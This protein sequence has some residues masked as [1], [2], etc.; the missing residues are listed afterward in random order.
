MKTGMMI[1]W[2][3]GT[4]VLSL[5][6]EETTRSKEEA[7]RL[8][9]VLEQSLK[10]DPNNSTLWVH[11]GFANR[12]LDDIDGALAAFE[13]ATQLNPK[14]PDALYMLAI[15][16]EKKERNADAVKAWK[17]LL[18]VTQDRWRRDL[19]EKHLHRLKTLP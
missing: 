6:S 13:K 10:S 15:I 5:R 11:L 2:T 18:D 19:A 9:T 7:A 8:K 16:Y 1:L 3:A 4:M 17:S 14:N 12:D